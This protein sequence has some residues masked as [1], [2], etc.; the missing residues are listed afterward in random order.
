MWAFLNHHVKNLLLLNA[1]CGFFG[2]PSSQK[3]KEAIGTSG[4]VLYFFPEEEMGECTTAKSSMAGNRAYEGSADA[5]L[6]S[7]K[8]V[9]QLGWSIEADEPSFSGRNGPDIQ[10]IAETEVWCNCA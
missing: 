1:L 3:V 5:F 2:D 9:E 4:K 10:E 7:K 6:K 8:M